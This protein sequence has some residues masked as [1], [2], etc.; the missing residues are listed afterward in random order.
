MSQEDLTSEQI[1]FEAT[2]SAMR[3]AVAAV[4]RDRLM[5]LAGRASAEADERSI[6]STKGWERLRTWLWPCATAASLLLA[7]GLGAIALGPSQV[8]ERIV[9]VER[10]RPVPVLPIPSSDRDELRPT[11]DYLRLRELVL[12]EGVDAI[13]ASSR[14]PDNGQAPVPQGP[15]AAD[16]KDLLG[17]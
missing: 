12:R 7:V 4:D 5:Y 15:T 13:P 11:A 17:S 10:E 2:L 6:A 9:Y 8:V 1:A 14:R 3:P 16:W